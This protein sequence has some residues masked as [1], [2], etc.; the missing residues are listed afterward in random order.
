MSCAFDLPHYRDLLEAAKAGGYRFA[1]FEGEPS[2][3]DVILR[4]D[5]DLSLDAALRMAERSSR[6]CAYAS[7]RAPCTEI[8][9]SCKSGSPCLT[10]APGSLNTRTTS[11]PSSTPSSASCPATTTPT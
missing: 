11:P 7:L 6:A 5:V 8:A 10:L 9:A 4:H 2:E 3:G 1:F